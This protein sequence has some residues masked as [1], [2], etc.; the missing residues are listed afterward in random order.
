MSQVVFEFFGPYNGVGCVVPVLVDMI[1][2]RMELMNHLQCM[3]LGLT[4]PVTVHGV[5]VNRA[6]YSAW[7]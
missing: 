3:G 5:G 6:G 2:H 7:N 4:E 1:S